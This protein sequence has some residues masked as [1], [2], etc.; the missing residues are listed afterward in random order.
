[1]R[2]LSCP[3]PAVASTTLRPVRPRPTALSSGSLARLSGVQIR[4]STCAPRVRE[5]PRAHAVDE[6]QF[7]PRLQ[8]LTQMPRRGSSEGRDGEEEE[9][10]RIGTGPTIHRDTTPLGALTT[11][12]GLPVRRVSAAPLAPRLRIGSCSCIVLA[13]SAAGLAFHRTP[14]FPPGVSLQAECTYR[15][16]GVWRAQACTDRGALTD[17]RPHRR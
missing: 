17:R 7:D 1:M 2:R 8:V 16:C 5:S 13:H 12:P 10:T 9:E 6:L 3:K 4:T 15:A 14:P 11:A